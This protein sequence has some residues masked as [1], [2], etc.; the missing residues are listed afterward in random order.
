MQLGAFPFKKT[1]D[2]YVFIS[3]PGDCVEERN[4]INKVILSVNEHDLTK[5]QNLRLIPVRWEDLPPGQTE[6]GDYQQRIDDLLE[7][8]NLN[9]F[10]IYIG[11]MKNRLGTPTANYQS[12][13][14]D[15]IH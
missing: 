4:L 8:L 2:V 5:S 15:E 1:T 7:K 13:T 9:H 10:D 6:G 11:C 3:S 12:G 14:V